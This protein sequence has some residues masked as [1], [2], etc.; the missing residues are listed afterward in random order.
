M[1]ASAAMLARGYNL[2]CM[3][4]RYQGINWLDKANWN[5]NRR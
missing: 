5:C 2:D 4:L 1:G 3:L